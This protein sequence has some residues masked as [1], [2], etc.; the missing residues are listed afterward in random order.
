M[1]LT[2][3][4]RSAALAGL[5]RHVFVQKSTLVVI[6]VLSICGS[7]AALAQ[8][9]LVG[10]IIDRVGA[11]ESL[12][13]LPWLIVALLIVGGLISGFLQYLI[14]RTA[15]VAIRSARVGLVDHI[16][17]LPIAT[18][19]RHRVGDLVSR[20]NADT[21]VIRSMLTQGFVESIAG[22]V[23]L[24]GALAA[25]WL[26]DP[27]LLVVSLGVALVAVFL[28]VMMT[29]RIEEA[30]LGVQQA[31]GRL[32]SSLDRA[33]RAVRTVR[34]ANMTGSESQ[35]VKEDVE[36]SW[37]AG[38]R[39]ARITATLAPV[40]SAAMQATFLVVLGLGGY[41]V[42]AGA[43][44]VSD[45]VSFI[46]FLFLM[47]MP[48]G[49]IFGTISAVGEAVGGM[50][51]IS[52]V[53]ELPLEADAGVATVTAPATGGSNV[54]EFEDVA[55]SYHDAPERESEDPATLAA[56]SF[57]VPRGERVAL[58]GP[59]GAGKSTLLQL[60]ARFYDVDGGT[61]R[62]NGV[63]T[64]GISREAVRSRIAYVEQEAPVPAGTLR[65]AVTLG[66]EAHTDTDIRELLGELDLVGVL[67]RSPLGLDAD[68]GEG[69]VLLSG[70]ERQRLAIARALLLK[71]DL[72][73]LDESTSHLDGVNEERVQAAIARRAGRYAMLVVAHRLA[74]VRSADR[75]LVLDAGRIVDSGRHDELMQ[76]SELYRDLARNQL[77]PL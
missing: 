44:T 22:V 38:L 7:G 3:E 35:R 5:F 37:A 60:I 68:L 73:L 47:I 15:E 27:L 50:V 13:M 74:T 55:F 6:V 77:L 69:G 42:A 24:I 1:S 40:S 57:E 36:A 30:S 31:V 33:I 52:E 26:I 2:R 48:L 56:V 53:M 39:V 70:G 43:L 41:Q 11:R 28:V 14:Q 59:S 25:M 21:S 58:V 66:S 76:T 67:E 75:I 62:F 4:K 34:A 63:D 45:L 32:S 17:R 65:D 61:I 71:P 20:V 9:W 19:D 51:R 18:L 8:P 54:L 12:G 16:L 29:S 72:L 64:A 49:Q 10:Q 46:L 23:T